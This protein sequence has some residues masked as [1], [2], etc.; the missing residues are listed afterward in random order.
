MFAVLI[1][2]CCI[3]TEDNG[4][5]WL[6]TEG[7]CGFLA[8]L[9]GGRAVDA[10]GKGKQSVEIVNIIVVAVFYHYKLCCVAR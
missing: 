7:A 6:S 9:P 4:C 2:T 8:Q 3:K 10:V 5:F 1:D